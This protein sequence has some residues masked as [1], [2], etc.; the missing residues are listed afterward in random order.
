MCPLSCSVFVVFFFI[1]H[2]ARSIAVV[3]IYLVCDS[4]NVATCPSIL[5]ARLVFCLRFNRFVFS[6]PEH[7]QGEL[8]GSLDVRRPSYVWTS[9]TSVTF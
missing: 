3:S 9:E 4:G 6:L 5:A 2:L 8:L 1:L 7:A